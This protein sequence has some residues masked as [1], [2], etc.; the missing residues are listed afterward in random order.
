CRIHCNTETIIIGITGLLSS[1]ILPRSKEFINALG[2][3]YDSIHVCPNNCVLFQKDYAKHDECPV[4]GA[5]RWKDTAGKKHIPEKVL[6][7]FPIIPRLKRFF[8]S[9][10]MSE[11]AQWHILKRKAVENV[12]SH[13]A[14]GEAWKDFD[15]KYG[16]FAKDARNIRLGLATDG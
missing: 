11:E 6:W 12:L 4:C 15:R 9:K 5:S 13:P 10:N 1:H 3:G 14:D 8:A 7:H 2:L 16:W